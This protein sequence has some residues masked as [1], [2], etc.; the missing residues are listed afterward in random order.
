MHVAIIGA[1]GLVGQEIHNQLTKR[2]FACSQI[3]LYARTSRGSIQALSVIDW[4]QIDLAFFAAGSAVSKEHI[5]HA[6]AS[7][8]K[9]IDSSSHF[10]GTATLI[11]PEI[12]GHLISTSQLIASPNCTASIALMAL[13]PLHA[14]SP[15][16]RIVASTYQAASGGG[17]KMMQA[18]L[19]NPLEFPLHLHNSFDELDYSGEEEKMCDEIR[20]ILSAPNLPISV[21][22]VRVP[23]ARAHSI[24]LN[25]EFEKPIAN[26]KSLLQSAK[27]LRLMD[28][29]TPNDATEC[30]DVLC[31]SVRQDPSHPN[32]L[33]LWVVGDQLL[34]GAALNAVQ[35]AEKC[36][37]PAKSIHE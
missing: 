1:S 7:G 4:S 28:R 2:A 25:V 9:V 3:S 10:R 34:K 13:H 14:H 8:C 5:P 6:L 35:I 18:L 30:D 33:E 19:N 37:N 23:V 26:P 32:C 22:C 17:H 12:N 27:G 36:T 15:I 31:G 29:P 21:R 24:A 20:L 16:K 11:I